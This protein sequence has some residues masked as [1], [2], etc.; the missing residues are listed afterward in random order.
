MKLKVC[1]M[2]HSDNIKEIGIL[3][4]DFLGFIFY[5]KSTRYFEGTIP[6]IPDSI[7]KVGVF[8]NENLTF[9]QEKVV[10]YQ[11]DLIQL[12]GEESVAFCKELKNTLQQ[13]QEDIKIIKVFSIK[14]EFD[15]SVLRAYEAHIDYFLFDTKGE[16]PGGNGYAFNWTVLENYPSQKPYLLSGGIGLENATAVEEFLHNKK[17][18]KHCFAIDVNSKFEGENNVKK[19]EDLSSFKTILKI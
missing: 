3:E 4:P 15:F 10:Q 16:L 11:F 8:V 17:A 18:S 13:T 19:V 14:N 6:E 2:K 12:H 5:K 1:G 7:K 9:I